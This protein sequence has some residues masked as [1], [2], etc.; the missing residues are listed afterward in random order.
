MSTLAGT[1]AYGLESPFPSTTSATASTC[2]EIGDLS[3]LLPALG[4]QPCFDW[5]HYFATQEAA[6]TPVPIFPI[7][8]PLHPIYHTGT[9]SH[10]AHEK[11]E[12]SPSLRIRD[13][14]ERDAHL[15]K[16]MGSSVELRG[17]HT[18]CSSIGSGLYPSF[19]PPYLDGHG[20]YPK[21]VDGLAD[22]GSNWYLISPHEPEFNFTPASSITHYSPP[23]TTTSLDPM[24]ILS[25]GLINDLH[26]YTDDSE[27]LTSDCSSLSFSSSSPP[28]PS[29]PTYSDDESVFLRSTYHSLGAFQSSQPSPPNFV[30]CHRPLP[31]SRQAAHDTKKLLMSSTKKSTLSERGRS[32]SPHKIRSSTSQGQKGI[33]RSAQMG[34][35]RCKPTVSSGDEDWLPLSNSVVRRAKSYP[36][37]RASPR[38]TSRLTSPRDDFRDERPFP[39][40]FPDCPQRCKSQG[41]LNRHL[42]SRAHKTPSFVC[43]ECSTCFTREDARARHCRQS[44]SGRGRHTCTDD[45]PNAF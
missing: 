19:T 17:H 11:G 41:D 43:H 6:N 36:K 25:L 24:D 42:Q 27:G 9:Q 15:A 33:H 14:S 44:C 7:L 23:S 3:L 4:L 22:Y 20:G 34:T 30:H 45:H 10:A 31:A 40:P 18:G 37:N 13:E 8:Q 35:T 16:T 5:A 21:Q 39:C 2:S 32:N 26:T 29:P 1:N 12:T 38:D 28:S